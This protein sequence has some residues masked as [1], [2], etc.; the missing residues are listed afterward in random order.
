MHLPNFTVWPI[1]V[2][3]FA[4]LLGQI[5][6]CVQRLFSAN[7]QTTMVSISDDKLTLLNK[8]NRD[9]CN[10]IN[11]YLYAR[12]FLNLLPSSFSKASSCFHGIICLPSMA[13]A[14]VER[15]W[16][17]LINHMASQSLALKVYAQLET[18][19]KQHC[20]LFGCHVTTTR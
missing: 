10:S 14:I 20:G 11:E 7:R 18:S 12:S 19:S 6:L 1:P 5:A 16:K 15:N 2:R 9:I 3:L 17:E 8:Q 13:I 4:E